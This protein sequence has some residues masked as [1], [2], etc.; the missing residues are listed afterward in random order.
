M[1]T[2]SASDALTVPVSTLFRNGDQW[3]VFADDSGR[4]KTLPV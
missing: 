3:A 1:T 2:W 4:A